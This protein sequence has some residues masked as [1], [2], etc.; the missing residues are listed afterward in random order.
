[1]NLARQLAFTSGAY[2]GKS[3]RDKH[4]AA[5]DGALYEF[6]ERVRAVLPAAPQRVWVA[7]D[8]PFFSG[9]AAYHLY[10]HNVHFEP[11]GR[12]MPDRAWV[13]AGDW[14]LVYYRRG[15]EFDGQR[16]LLRWEGGPGI[17]AERKAS[18]AGAALFLLH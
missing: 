4:L 7:S 13:K 18:G 6:V 16:N 9:R 3:E 14:M 2:G 15:V 17:P 12:A 1:V 11:R 8:E 10:P 5:A